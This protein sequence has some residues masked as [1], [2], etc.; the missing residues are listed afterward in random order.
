MRCRTLPVEHQSIAGRYQSSTG[1]KPAVDSMLIDRFME[2]RTNYR[3]HIITPLT[4]R[5]LTLRLVLEP[6]G[7]TRHLLE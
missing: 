6:L 7:L 5:K 3:E 1:A 2:L 4:E